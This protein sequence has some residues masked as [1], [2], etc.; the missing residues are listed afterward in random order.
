MTRE[1][2]ETLI[3]AACLYRPAWLVRNR[4]RIEP[5]LCDNFTRRAIVA[6]V[7]EGAGPDGTL[8][9]GQLGRYLR[10]RRNVRALDLQREVDEAS[11]FEPF[12]DEYFDRALARLREPID[13]A[14]LAGGL[15]V[16]NMSLEREVRDLKDRLDKLKREREEFWGDLGEKLIELKG[17][18]P[19]AIKAAAKKKGL[20][21]DPEPPPKPGGPIPL[22]GL[23]EPV[24]AVRVIGTR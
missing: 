10:A 9:H 11:G 19:E 6:G 17:G 13:R 20:F 8:D 1:D 3:V 14:D 16:R 4:H 22:A 18:D 12:D 7:L 23:S 24:E 21:K 15:Q 5:Y 2:R